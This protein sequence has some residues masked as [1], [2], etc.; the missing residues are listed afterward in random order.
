MAEEK[1]QDL[2]GKEKIALKAAPGHKLPVRY[3]GEW[4]RVGS[5]ASVEFQVAELPY[6]A[7][8]EIKAA[9]AAKTVLEAPAAPAPAKA[10]AKKS[11][12]EA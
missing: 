12:K 11:A 1:K 7:K 9:I 5:D 2:F 10:E 8:L 6:E 4:V 3:R